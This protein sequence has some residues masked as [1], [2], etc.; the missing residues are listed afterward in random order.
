MADGEF[1]VNPYVGYSDLSWMDKQGAGAGPAMAPED[2]IV[3]APGRRQVCA[4]ELARVIELLRDYQVLVG[5]H[6]CE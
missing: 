3:E 5:P 2:H 4:L 1:E 6:A